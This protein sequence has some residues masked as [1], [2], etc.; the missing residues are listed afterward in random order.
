MAANFEQL[1][2]VLGLVASDEQLTREIFGNVNSVSKLIFYGL[3]FLSLGIFAWGVWRRIRLWGMGRPSKSKV[4]WRA[5]VRGFWAKV[6]TQRTVRRTKR[7]AGAMHALM[8]WGFS[9]LFVGTILVGIEEYAS[10]ILG[11]GARDPLFHKGLYFAI[12]EV[13]LDFFGLFFLAGCV[14]FIRRRLRAAKTSIG[15]NV[16]DWVVIVSF[17]AIGLT[18]YFVEALRIIRESTPHPELSFVGFG[19]SKL[20]IAAG[21][22][23]ANADPIHLVLWWVHAILVFGIIAAF[24]YT[25]LLH[26]IAGGLNLAT[27]EKNLG[28][29]EPVTLE[30]LE[31]T[32]KVGVERLQD[33]TRRQLLSLDACVSCGR[34]EDACPAFEAGKPL[35]PR[36]VV[37]DL[38]RSLNAVGPRMSHGEPEGPGLHGEVIKPESLWSCT[39]CQACTD[40]CPLAVDPVGLITDMRRFLIGEGALSGPPAAALQK[41]QRSGN[42]WGLPKQDRFD[43]AEGLEVATVLTNPEFEVL[44][45][46]GCAAS[47]DRRAQKVA[48]AVVKLLEIAG[49]NYA[50]LGPEERCNGESA[51][52]MGDEFLFQELAGE[53]VKT[54]VKYKVRKIVT[55]CPH[56][57]NSFKKDYP[58]V[59]GDYEVMHH[60]QLLSQLVLDGSLVVDSWAKLREGKKGSITFHDPCYLARANGISEEPRRLIEAAAGPESLVEMERN[61]CRT[62]CCGAGGGRM[63][64]DDAVDERIGIG[65]VR[66]AVETGAQTVAVSCPFCLTMVGDGLAAS[67]P[68][69]KTIDVAELLAEAIGNSKPE[70]APTE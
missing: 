40:V 5:G 41:V 11:R 14:W 25:R 13:A 15:H 38:W 49:V 23:E 66:E 43:W 28:R 51:R 6:M 18:G 63:W 62:A 12:Y 39:T 61:R 22:S 8:F 68:E 34:C 10:L 60:T 58:Q 17:L 67:A 37:Q 46:I 42:P 35:S 16:L 57:L 1:A 55:H 54:L 44:Y 26:V 36:D 48:R 33:L 19:V 70:D 3:A 31:E 69:I 59:G 4:D 45:W 32:G 50:T 65:R 20:F 53:N 64:F 30:E 7:R 56:C 2:S 47:Y 9:V 24:P 27:A 21:V 52:R 29:L